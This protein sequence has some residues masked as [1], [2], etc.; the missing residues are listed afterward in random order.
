MADEQ[1]VT[2]DKV[3]SVDLDSFTDNNKNGDFKKNALLTENLST[4]TKAI[5]HSVDVEGKKIQIL[6]EENQA[7]SRK[8]LLTIGGMLCFF[9]IAII[10]LVGAVIHLMKDTKILTSGTSSVL[11]TAD[12][13]NSVIT[14]QG[15]V[16]DEIDSEASFSSLSSVSHIV[17]E[18]GTLNNATA[19]NLTPTGYSRMLCTQADCTSKHTLFFYTTEALVVYHG[20]EAYLLNPSDNLKYLLEHKEVTP[21]P[22]H[23]RHLLEFSDSP[24]FQSHTEYDH[25]NPEHRRLWESLGVGEYDHTNEAHRKLWWWALVGYVWKAVRGYV[26]RWVRDYAGRWVQRQ[27]ACYTN[28]YDEYGSPC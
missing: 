1:V 2:Y 13:K 9:S 26:W 27:V 21:V 18:F 11:M 19:I 4:R 15:I 8:L 7:K 20:K 6:I 10:S 28:G 3:F 23:A 14:A 16:F 17:L 22:Q 5:V 12:G 25:G 24:K